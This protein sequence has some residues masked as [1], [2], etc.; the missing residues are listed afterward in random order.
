MTQHS[1]EYEDLI[2]RVAPAKS[3]EYYN[4]LYTDMRKF[5]DNNVN[6]EG[7]D[8]RYSHFYSVVW[9]CQ[10]LELSQGDDKHGTSKD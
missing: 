8:L 4:K 7:Q 2:S 3:P 9:K 5:I 6:G 1:K 10:T